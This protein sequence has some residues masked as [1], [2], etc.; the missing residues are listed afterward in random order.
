MRGGLGRLGADAFVGVDVGRAGQGRGQCSAAAED[1]GGPADQQRSEVRRDRL[2]AALVEGGVPGDGDAGLGEPVPGLAAVEPCACRRSSS[3]DAHAGDCSCW[4]QSRSKTVATAWSASACTPGRHRST[5][6]VAFIPHPR[7]TGHVLDES[8][9]P[10]AFLLGCCGGRLGEPVEEGLPGPYELGEGSLMPRTGRC[11]KCG[12]PTSV[13]WWTKRRGRPTGQPGSSSLPGTAGQ[14]G[15]TM[16]SPLT[17]PPLLSPSTRLR[18]LPQ[19][20]NFLLSRLLPATWYSARFT[21][22]A[23]TPL[24]RLEDQP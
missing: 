22:P 24:A 14:S 16:M 21:A 1:V 4:P 10:F 12:S 3:W 5:D 7:I 20:G 6:G 9:E 13:A 23:K 17:I 2:R 15:R 19:G 18:P 8:A 11:P